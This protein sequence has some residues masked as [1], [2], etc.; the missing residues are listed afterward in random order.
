MDGPH[1]FTANTRAVT[2][3]AAARGKLLRARGWAVISVPFFRWAGMPD[4][5]RAAWLHQASGG[6]AH[7]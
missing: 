4:A 5:A 6:S 7:P 3:E 1:H 2:G